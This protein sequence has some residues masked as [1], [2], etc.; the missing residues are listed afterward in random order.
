[1]QSFEQLIGCNTYDDVVNLYGLQETK[2]PIYILGMKLAV[3]S[4]ESVE[5]STNDKVYIANVRV[6]G[7]H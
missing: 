6:T 7:L 3:H 2:E 5:Y 1:M 4:V